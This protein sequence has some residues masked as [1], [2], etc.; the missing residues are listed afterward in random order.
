MDNSLVSSVEC[1]AVCRHFVYVFRY[2]FSY[3]SIVVV[4]DQ[5]VISWGASPTYG[6]LVSHEVKYALLVFHKMMFSVNTFNCFS[7]WGR[8]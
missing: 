8:C 6:E 5:S 1:F 3:K 7:V 4:A 2:Y